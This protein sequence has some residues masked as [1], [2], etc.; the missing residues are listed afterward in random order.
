M[1]YIVL[2]LLSLTAFIFIYNSHYKWTYLF[3]ISLFALF[4]GLMLMLS[5]QWQR[6]L[7]FSAVLFIILMLFHRLKIHYYKQPLL[8]SDFWLSFD[9]RNW[10][11]LLHYKGALYGVIGLFALLGYGVMGWSSAESLPSWVRLAGFTLMFIAGYLIVHYS[12][13]PD[14]IKV[15]LDSLP[16]D[17]RDV[18]LNIPISCRGVWFKV[19]EFTGDSDYF[20]Q[21]MAT[22]S[23]YPISEQKPDIVA[24]LCESTCNPHQFDLKNAMLP[25]LAM[26]ESQSN[27]LFHSPLRVHTYAGATWMSEFAF[28]GGVPSTDFGAMAS[29]V[30]YSVAPHLRVSFLKSLQAQGYYCVALSPFTK[31][32][33]NAKQA[34]DHLGI[35]LML[36]P[37][38][39]GYPAPKGKNLWHIS[40]QEMVDYAKQ[41][42]ERKSIP[43]LAQFDK[44]LFVYVL[45]M[46]EHGPYQHNVADTYQ[47]AQSGFNALA[48]SEI[49]DYINRLVDLDKAITDLDDYLQQ[50][51]Q[52]YVF[53]YFGDHQVGLGGQMMPMKYTY[54]QPNYVTQFTVRSNLNNGF[55]QQQ[56]FIDL[57]QAGG[58]ILEIAGIKTDEFMQANIAMRKLSKYG[59]QDCDD[60]TLLNS[61]RHYLYTDLKIVQ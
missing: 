18:F 45:T 24:F 42:L 22:L 16:D 35:D 6:A 59:L 47:I 27:C 19:P 37:Q 31:G 28:L 20:R 7:N 26:F 51:N 48:T 61:Y 32:N 57:A 13:N 52:P 39:L 33:Y 1:E 34:Y 15:W 58:V 12:K 14:A 9:P 8:I 43:A 40:S 17:G 41:I 53:A 2:A 60:P 25:P 46:R 5:A 4:F 36:Q 30:F 44:P 56:S 38:D 10:E 21:K 54:P 11:T 3:A 23:A 29:S 50:R 49:N 55:S